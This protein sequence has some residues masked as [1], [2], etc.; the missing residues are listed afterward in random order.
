MNLLNLNMFFDIPANRCD[1][2][3]AFLKDRARGGYGLGRLALEKKGW[4][5]SPSQHCVWE[6]IHSSS[7]A[8]NF[9]TFHVADLVNVPFPYER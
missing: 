7:Q 2:G 3:G 1:G 5:R 6:G 9:G 4:G 8:E